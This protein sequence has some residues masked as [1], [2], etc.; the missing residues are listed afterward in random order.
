M[1]K[2]TFLFKLMGII[3]IAVL[4]ISCAPKKSDEQIILEARVAELQ[5]ELELLSEIEAQAEQGIELTPEQAARIAE[6]RAEL[7]DAKA[8]LETVVAE[9]RQRGRSGQ[10]VE[11][12]TT[13]G[14]HIQSPDNSQQIPADQTSI[15]AP[16][17]QL[18]PLENITYTTS[19]G[20][21]TIT[22][23]VIDPD[24]YVHYIIPD[25]IGGMP[26][27][28]I[29]NNAFMPEQRPPFTSENTTLVGITIPS[30]VTSIGDSAFSFCV[31]LTSI[32]IPA[33]V[34]TIGKNAFLHCRRLTS[35]TFISP[36]SLTS[37]GA[38]TFTNTSI[39]S[40]TIPSGVTRIEDNAFNDARSL[41]SV[42]FE[43][44]S[45][46]TSIGN[47]AF[48]GCWNL[49]SITIPSSVTTI[50][51]RAFYQCRNLASVT[52]ASPSSLTRIGNE[53]F[54]NCGEGTVTIPSTVTSIG[55][56]AFRGAGFTN[57]TFASPSSLTTIG[58]HAFRNSSITS[59][60]IPQGVTRIEERTFDGSSLTNFTIPTWIT[61]IGPGAF[62][63]TKITSITIP[64]GITKIETSTFSNMYSLTS[65]TFASPSSVAV[66]GGGAFLSNMNLKNIDIPL[67]V[68]TIEASAFNGTGLNEITLSRGTEVGMFA[69][70]RAGA[71]P[72]DGSFPV[73]YR[74]ADAPRPAP[75][76]P[77][78][79]TPPATPGSG[80][81]QQ[82]MP[83]VQPERRVR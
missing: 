43:T 53:A 10:P 63:S 36:S 72:L 37:I 48:S 33:A 13:T 71:N 59:F 19:G 11:V 41:S 58:A 68:H 32:N 18:I 76:T 47:A 8:E 20:R 7:D 81:E 54:Y 70:P 46:V 67:S 25:T 5:A 9:Q 78:Q 79:Q 27:T 1:N 75:Q 23:V 26:V 40:I 4:I 55:E 31:G 3:V 21:V 83:P 30:T 15:T 57:I 64:S 14:G 56:S 77:Q 44:P 82:T 24:N 49:K 22:N 80:T 38:E 6:I 2:N 73:H 50:G 16:T 62:N 51:N 12:E 42:I 60:T 52:F 66:I 61:Y 65:V 45:S 28:A 69:F 34:T 17:P 29:G 74:D 35:I 39:M